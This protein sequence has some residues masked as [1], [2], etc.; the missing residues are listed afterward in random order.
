[1]L[2]CNCNA[3]ARKLT[4]RSVRNFVRLALLRFTAKAVSATRLRAIRTRACR[5]AAL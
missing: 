5:L 4:C 3:R 1:V 2:G